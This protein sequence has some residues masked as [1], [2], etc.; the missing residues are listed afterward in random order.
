MRE[1]WE[2]KLNYREFLKYRHRAA[3]RQSHE[4]EVLTYVAWRNLQA[5]EAWRTRL[6]AC[7]TLAAAHPP[8]SMAADRHASTNVAS[9]RY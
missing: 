5:V 2:V 9:G 6:G 4:P 8:L 7:S 3:P 1:L